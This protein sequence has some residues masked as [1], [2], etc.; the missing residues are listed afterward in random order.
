MNIEDRLKKLEAEVMELKYQVRAQQSIIAMR[1]TPIWAAKAAEL[2]EINGMMKS[3][4]GN[5]LDYYRIIDFLQKK[6]AL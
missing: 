4:I 3:P 1:A 5:S 6:G 2:A